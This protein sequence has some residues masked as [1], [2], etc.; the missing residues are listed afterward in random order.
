MMIWIYKLQIAMVLQE[1]T[2]T[3]IERQLDFEQFS[4][5]QLAKSGKIIIVQNLR[6]VMLLTFHS[7]VSLY[8][9]IR[10]SRLDKSRGLLLRQRSD[11]E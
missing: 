10:W 2:A 11:T 1:T 9:G 5:V 8:T 4:G 3:K 7:Y 6:L